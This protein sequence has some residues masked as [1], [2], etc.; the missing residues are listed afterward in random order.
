M[1]QSVFL[2]EIAGNLTDF[3]TVKDKINCRLIN[4]SQHA[5][6]LSGRPHTMV[7]DLAVTYH[8]E[9]GKSERGSMTAPITNMLMEQYGVDTKD[10]HTLALSNME[11]LT[12]A[13]FKGMSE[14]MTELLLPDAM[15]N[16][17]SR[18]EAEQVLQDLFPQGQSEAMYVLSNKERLHG[19]AAL[20]NESIMDE[21]TGKLG[22]EYYILPSSIHEVLIVPK[23][24]GM[25]I[26]DL[27]NMVCDVNATQVSPKERLSDNVYAY[28]AREHTLF[29]VDR[30]A[31]RSQEKK[32]SITGALK[33]PL[34]D[35][36][37]HVV[38]PPV[39]GD[40]AR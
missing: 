4:A 37:S 36:G 11:H 3:D 39:K 2:Q 26:S 13:S 8:I 10:L 33:N 6:E 35:T 16:G 38:K 27:K 19:A 1:T 15:S 20:L 25:D 34:P 28:D 17:M 18:E 12:P 5:E 14:T 31:E 32:P 29:R 21:V 24:E 23:T 40:G 9:I 7:D 22:K 30:M